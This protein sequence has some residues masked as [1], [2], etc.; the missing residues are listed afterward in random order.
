MLANLTTLEAS[1]WVDPEDHSETGL[2]DPSRVITLELADG[3]VHQLFIG[4]AAGQER[5]ADHYCRL[6]DGDPFQIRSF[7]ARQLLK[8]ADLLIPE[9]E[10]G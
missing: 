8:S 6:D 4:G 7:K 10:E 3:V 1:R 2:D 5:D 9:A